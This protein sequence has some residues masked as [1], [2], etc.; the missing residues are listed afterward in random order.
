[1]SGGH[2]QLNDVRA[3]ELL[4]AVGTVAS[5]SR[6]ITVQVEPDR[7]FEAA[8]VAKDVLGCAFFNFLTAIDWK[9]QGLEI[10][11]WLDNLEAGLAV[12]LR[13]KLGAGQTACASLVPLFRGANWMERE[14]FDMFGVQFAGHPDPRRILLADDWEGHP[15]LKSYAVDTPHPPYR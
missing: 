11:A 10:V 4:G 6:P 14:C 13:T 7:W 2:D 12:E 1:M 9:E 3:R 15:L 8:R 5:A